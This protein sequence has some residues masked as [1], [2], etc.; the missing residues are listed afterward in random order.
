MPH[1][2]HVI[3][4]NSRN[5][6]DSSCSIVLQHIF[7]MVVMLLLLLL[8]RLLLLARQQEASAKCVASCLAS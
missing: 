2:A 5:S 3:E 6:T 4:V 7:V 1:T 8:L